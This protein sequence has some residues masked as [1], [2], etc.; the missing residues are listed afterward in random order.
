[1]KAYACNTGGKCD[2]P[3]FG[4]IFGGGRHYGAMVGFQRHDAVKAYLTQGAA[5]ILLV[6]HSGIRSPVQVAA[7]VI[8]V[9]MEYC[10]TVTKA[11][12]LIGG[13]KT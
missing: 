4:V 6:G 11:S 7:A 9:N 13:G 12:C 8:I 2:Q 1:M 10:Q 5:E 3:L